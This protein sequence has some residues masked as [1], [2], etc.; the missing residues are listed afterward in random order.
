MPSVRHNTIPVDRDETIPIETA[1]FVPK[2]YGV[3]YLVN[4]IALA[5][6]HA[7]DN[8]LASPASSDICSATIA[9]NKRHVVEVSGVGGVSR[10]EFD[11]RVTLPVFDRVMDAA[12][13]YK[14]GVNLI[15]YRVILPAI[16]DAYNSDAKGLGTWDPYLG[17]LGYEIFYGLRFMYG[18]QN[19]ASFK[20]RE[21]IYRCV[22]N[23]LPFLSY[24]LDPSRVGGIAGQKPI[25]IHAS[26]LDRRAKRD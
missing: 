14:T 11:G 1:L 19:D 21:P 13:I 4:A 22:R 8:L 3:S 6:L 20:D 9:R 26:D 25:V 16:L 12:L 5:A 15:G 24:W 23:L 10:Y 18:A 2:P 7:E 17:I